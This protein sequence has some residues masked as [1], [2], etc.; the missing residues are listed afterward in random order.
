MV[1]ALLTLTLGLL[2][3]LM[4]AGTPPSS[5]RFRAVSERVTP[6]LQT[7]LREKALRFGDPIFIR[8]FKESRELDLWVRHS[9]GR[10]RLFK[11]YAIAMFSGSLGPILRE[12]DSQTPEGFYFVPPSMMNPRSDFHLSFNLGFPN[13]HD[14]AHQRI[15]SF[16]MIHGGSVSIG[17]YAMTDPSIEEIYTLADAALRAGQ[18][19][20]R[21]HCFPFRMTDDR[22]SRLELDEKRWEG[23]WRN[24]KEGYDHFERHQTPPDVVVRDQRYHF[25]M[26]E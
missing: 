25:R 13:P 20:F 16:L 5:E 18:P 24:L 23:D 21:V 19:F 8:L 12:G 22:M 26:G 10:F 6:R 11:N 15:G 7:Q 1:P 17:C 14:R 2:T 4:K 3:S 9:S